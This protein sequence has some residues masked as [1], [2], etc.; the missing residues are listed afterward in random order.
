MNSFYPRW[1]VAN[2]WSEGF[3]P[4][5]YVFDRKSPSTISRESEHVA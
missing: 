5:A 2:V 3:R 1:I 4:P